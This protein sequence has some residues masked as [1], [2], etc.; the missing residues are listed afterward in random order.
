MP[1]SIKG[2]GHENF[3][4]NGRHCSPPLTFSQ[5]FTN[6]QGHSAISR[7]KELGNLF[8]INTSNSHKK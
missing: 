8:T 2:G 4:V 1:T 6:G 3:P 5:A 7:T